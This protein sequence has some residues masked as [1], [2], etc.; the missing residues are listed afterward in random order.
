MIATTIYI[1]I[2]F[3]ELSEQAILRSLAGSQKNLE[4]AT[5]LKWGKL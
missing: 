4:I 2:L 5:A 1:T 3:L